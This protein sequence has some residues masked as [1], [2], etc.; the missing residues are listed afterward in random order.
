M[1]AWDVSANHHLCESPDMNQDFWH[2]LVEA[3]GDSGLDVSQ[4]AI[5]RQLDLGQSAVAK[6]AH[7]SGYPTLRKCIQIARLT[8]VSVEWLLTGRGNKKLEGNDM[9]DMTQSLLERWS[10]LPEPAKR[11]ILEFVEFR[12]AK[13]PAPARGPVGPRTTRKK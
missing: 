10:D 7:G 1:D 4:S 5:A 2:R 11:E 12:A 6:W 8:G 9:D 3:F 13:E